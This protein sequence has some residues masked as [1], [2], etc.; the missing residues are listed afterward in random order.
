MKVYSLI[1]SLIQCLFMKD[2]RLH[3]SYKKKKNILLK[4]IYII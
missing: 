2:V 3:P 1:E 4:D